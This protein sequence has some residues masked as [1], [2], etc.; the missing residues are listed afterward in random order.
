MISNTMNTKTMQLWEVCQAF[1][2]EHEILCVDSVYQ[3]DAIVIDALAFIAKICDIVG[4]YKD[5]EEPALPF[6]MVG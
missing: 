5:K 3:Q 4:Y 2:N 1:I 6:G